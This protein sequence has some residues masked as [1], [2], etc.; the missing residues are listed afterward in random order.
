MPFNLAEFTGAL[1][2]HGVIQTNKFEVLIHESRF[3]R[4]PFNL[5]DS[6]I[7]TEEQ[8]RIVYRMLTNRIESVKLPGLV[9]DT[10][11]S[12]RY[13][14]GP[15]VSVGTNV[16]FEPLSITILSDRDMIVHKFFVAWFNYIF[17][18]MSTSRNSTPTFLNAYKE[19][20]SATISVKVFNNSGTIAAADANIRSAADTYAFYEAFPVSI[21]EPTLSWSSNNNLYRFDVNFLYTNWTTELP[22]NQN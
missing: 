4:F 6:N 18:G 16:S 14:I 19:D 12:R 11:D 17:D 7:I 10:F 3:N 22:N 1:S 15:K 13:G 8:Q 5:I 21:S 20:Y 2:T 9:I